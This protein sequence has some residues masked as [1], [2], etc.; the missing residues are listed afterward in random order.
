M[1]NKTIGLIL[2]VAIL[3]GCAESTNP[4]DTDNPSN[5]ITPS[6]GDDIPK[7]LPGEVYYT[8]YDGGLTDMSVLVSTHRTLVIEDPTVATAELVSIEIPVTTVDEMIAELKAAGE[9]LSTNRENRLRDRLANPTA[10]KL[11]PLK[12]GFTYIEATRPASSRTGQIR[13]ESV[14]YTPELRTLVV[15]DYSGDLINTGKIRYDQGANGSPACTACHGNT[16]GGAP[17]HQIGR[18]TEISDTDA[19]SWITT[20]R[21][22]DRVF[23]SSPGVQNAANHSWS[24]TNDTEKNA[25]VAYLRSQQTKDIKELAQLLFDEALAEAKAENIN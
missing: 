23:E 17:S 1:F 16:D 9:E 22:G 5:K 6:A 24:F 25:T 8:G 14:W 7:R 11:T 20:G 3:N 15:E 2:S 4:G 21:A 13:P 10:W 18:V 12:P 19:I